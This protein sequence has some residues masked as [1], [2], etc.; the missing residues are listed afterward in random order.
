[1]TSLCLCRWAKTCHVK[2]LQGWCRKHMN[3][4]QSRGHWDGAST[5]LRQACAWLAEIQVIPDAAAVLVREV[6]VTSAALL[7]IVMVEIPAFSTSRNRSVPN[8]LSQ[9]LESAIRRL[10]PSRERSLVAVSRAWRGAPRC[11]ASY[12]ASTPGSR[13]QIR[14]FFGWRPATRRKRQQRR[15]SRNSWPQIRSPYPV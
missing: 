8:F 11:A 10:T 5:P 1:M 2:S 9:L 13:S 12:V 3:S 15:Q 7:K 6:E 4:S 14:T